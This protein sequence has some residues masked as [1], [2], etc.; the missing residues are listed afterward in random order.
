MREGRIIPPGPGS[1]KSAG[2][3]EPATP[4]R[5]GWRALGRLAARLSQLKKAVTKKQAAFKVDEYKPLFMWLL[6][7]AFILLLLESVLRERRRVRAPRVRAGG[8]K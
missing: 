3:A 4:P 2:D 8:V 5:R 7:P 1:S 6:L